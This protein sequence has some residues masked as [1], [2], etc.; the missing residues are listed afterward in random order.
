[1]KLDAETLHVV[2][3]YLDEHDAPVEE[4]TVLCVIDGV[5]Y[6]LD[7]AGCWR[8]VQSPNDAGWTKCAPPAALQGLF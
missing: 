4:R 3:Q 7:D 8:F 1:M 5:H 6:R 2:G